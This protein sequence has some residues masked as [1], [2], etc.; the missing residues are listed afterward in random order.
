MMSDQ[1]LSKIEKLK[2]KREQLNARIKQVSN[3]EHDKARKLDARRNMLVGA[4]F[5]EKAKQAGTLEEIYQLMDAYL[6]RKADRLLF[7]LSA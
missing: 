7:D 1:K 3:R 2:L 5:L 4:Y 6:K